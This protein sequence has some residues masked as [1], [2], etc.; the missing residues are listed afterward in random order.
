M[1]VLLVDDHAPIRASLRQLLELRPGYDVVAE[2]A[3]GREAVEAVAEHEP[4]VVLMDMSMPVM[5]GVE[6][7]RAIKE[8]H[9]DVKVLALTAFGDMSLVA[10]SI[11]AGASGYLLKGGSAEELLNSLEAVALG[12][13][14]L[15][16]EV[17]GG[18][19]DDAADLYRR[20]QERAASLEELD[21]MKSEFVAV[22]SHELRTPL[23]G[24]KGGVRTLQEGW[25]RLDDVT[26]LELLDKIDRQCDRLT[27]LVDQLLTVS[28]IQNGAL[29]LG[30]ERFSLAEVARAVATTL[31]RAYPGRT[32]DVDVEDEVAVIADRGRVAQTALA[33]VENALEHTDG[34]V[35]VAL[36]ASDGSARLAI[37]DEGPGIEPSV[38][39]RLLMQP[40][41]QADSSATRQ[42]GGLGVSLYIAR[43]V[44]DASGGSL[45]TISTPDGGSTFT[46]VLPL[47]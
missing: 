24:I 18:V 40:F 44:L 21:R 1:K 45:E 35:R 31:E 4:D 38:L 13:G 29:G 8:R 20:E 15:D 47:P 41:E 6:A 36:S 37:E 26:K 22:V 42:V 30:G 16:R 12:Q 34:R 3:N 28:G 19:I 23:T 10:A 14:A 39:D 9:P 25:P 43:R 46:M 11:K 7:T 5:N 32:I 33:L 27:H 2:G 17:A